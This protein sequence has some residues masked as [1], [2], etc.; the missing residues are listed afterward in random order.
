MGG[1][2]YWFSSSLD[3]GGETGRKNMERVNSPNFE[4]KK[5]LL[6]ILKNFWSEK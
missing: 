2:N 5:I 6:A 3:L 1:V 4:R